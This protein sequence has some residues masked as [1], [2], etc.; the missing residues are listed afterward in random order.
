MSEKKQEILKQVFA[1]YARYGIKSITMDDVASELG[2]SKKTLYQIF[3]DK[4]DLVRQVAQTERKNRMASLEALGNS[5]MNAIRQMIMV[6]RGVNRMMDEYSPPYL[7]DL[8]KYYPG[9]YNE[10]KEESRK[11]MYGSVIRNIRQ[12]KLE[13][14]YRKKLD[15]E[16]IAKLYLARAE[17]MHDSGIFTES[18]FHSSGFFREVLEYHIRGLATRKGLEVLEKS[19]ES[20][21]EE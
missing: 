2:I 12:G 4:H 6:L 9:L 16:I 14:L 17:A 18:E 10:F 15:E 1:L 11:K 8:K 21:D 13:G 5:D 19:L 7:Y 3:K 20:L